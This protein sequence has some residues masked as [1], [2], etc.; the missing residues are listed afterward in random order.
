[1]DAETLEQLKH[2]LKKLEKTIMYNYDFKLFGNCLI[3][4]NKIDDVY[5]CILSFLPKN[6]KTALNISKFANNTSI[7]CYKI[8]FNSLKGKFM[9]SNDYYLVKYKEAIYG[10]QGLITSID[11]DFDYIEKNL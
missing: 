10:I 8:L 7:V 6:F 11:K 3:K 1:M 4:K 9:L 2:Y 5:V